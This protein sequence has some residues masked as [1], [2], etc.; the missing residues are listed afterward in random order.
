MHFPS[1]QNGLINCFNVSRLPIVFDQYFTILL[2]L[3]VLRFKY[4]T[5]IFAKQSEI[6]VPSELVAATFR[7]SGIYFIDQSDP[8]RFSYT[9]SAA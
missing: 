7:K 4:R 9:E 1:L 2:V 3:I 5:M 6:L 8:R